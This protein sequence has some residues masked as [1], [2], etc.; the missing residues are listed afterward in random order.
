V[1]HPVVVNADKALRQIAQLNSW[2]VLDS[3]R[4]FQGVTLDGEVLPGI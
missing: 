1:G 3:K 2:P 4:T